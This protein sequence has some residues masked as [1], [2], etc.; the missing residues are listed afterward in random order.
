MALVLTR[1]NGEGVDIGNDI[2]ITVR[3]LGGRARLE[4]SAPDEMTIIRS[5][6]RRPANRCEPRRQQKSANTIDIA[7]T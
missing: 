6:L 4:I 1:S 3:I 2:H 5:E 7:R